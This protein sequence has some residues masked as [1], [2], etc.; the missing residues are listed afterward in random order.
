MHS[1]ELL[2]L[3]HMTA[4]KNNEN[5]TSKVQAILVFSDIISVLNT[6]YFKKRDIKVKKVGKA[7][8]HL[9]KK[10]GY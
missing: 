9:N 7:A 3:V 10:P 4:L 8:Y 1:P 2:L 6:K 5:P